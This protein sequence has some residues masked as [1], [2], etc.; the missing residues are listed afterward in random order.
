MLNQNDIAL[1]LMVLMV[2][3]YFY[4]R[5]TDLQVLTVRMALDPI[6]SLT[7]NQYYSFNYH[8]YTISNGNNIILRLERTNNDFKCYTSRAYYCNSFTRYAYELLA[9]NK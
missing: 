9:S 4:D 3:R 5:E 8:C 6:C 1:G 7:I 2:I